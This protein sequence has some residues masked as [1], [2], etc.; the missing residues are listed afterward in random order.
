M[1]MAKVRPLIK[2]DQALNAEQFE[3]IRSFCMAAPP[4]SDDLPIDDKEAIV[5][6]SDD[7]GVIMIGSGADPACARFHVYRVAG[8]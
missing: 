5:T 1:R 3:F 2:H 8:F 6:D 4:M 7:F